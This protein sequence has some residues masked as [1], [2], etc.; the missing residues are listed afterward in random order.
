LIN[1]KAWDPYWHEVIIFLAGQLT[2]PLP[3]FTLLTRVKQDDI[4]RHR[5]ALAA[6]C[7]PEALGVERPQLTALTDQIT[8]ETVTY[9]L[10]YEQQGKK[11]AV[12]HLT[13]TLPLLGAIDGHVKTIPLWKWLCQQLQERDKNIRA[14]VI[15][16]VGHMG[17]IVAQ[18]PEVLSILTTLLNDEDALIRL[19]IITALR[20]IG[21][22][23]AAHPNVM[24]ALIQTAAHDEERF[25]RLSARRALEQI[26]GAE[27]IP[28]EAP[29]SDSSGTT[30]PRQNTGANLSLPTLISDSIAALHDAESGVR[31][32]AVE[33][34]T[35]GG[36]A[37]TQ[38]PHLLPL[39]CEVALHDTDGGVRMRAIEALGQIG[40][41]SPQFDM[42]IFALVAALRDRDENVRTYAARAFA[43]IGERSVFRAEVLSALLEALRDEDSTVSFEA[44]DALAR[45]M[46]QGV[47][48]FQSW[49]GK[50]EGKRVTDLANLAG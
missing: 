31:A 36:D 35:H 1:H 12:P 44:A 16:A 6:M 37:I 18:Q 14:S 42:A 30:F 48:I 7:L 33:A 47:R 10:Q 28:S 38:H 49:W 5:L 23:A 3:L 41:N 20:R 27:T 13:R 17:E 43:Q 9:W 15:E 11:T 8:T 25:I 50:F 24:P 29:R 40:S 21:I 32:S 39:L 46:S 45:L 19:R 26:G 34:I 2:D 4:F 22:A